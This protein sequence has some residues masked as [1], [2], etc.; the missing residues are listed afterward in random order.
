[1]DGLRRAGLDARADRHPGEGPLG[2]LLTAWQEVSSDVL[3]ALACDHLA[4]S[5]AA[6]GRLLDA[7]GHDPTAVAAIP[8]VDGRWQPLHA[9]HRRQGAA[10]LGAAF[11]A[12]ERSLKRALRD[13][14]VVL[15]S[16]IAAEALADADTPDDLPSV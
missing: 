8:V 2:G 1:L 10:A 9:A 6:V 14:R 3:V 15:V 12:G 7:L 11:A 4:P 16:G 5:P 13:A